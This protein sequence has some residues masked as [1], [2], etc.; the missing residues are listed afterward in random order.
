MVASQAI[1]RDKIMSQIENALEDAADDLE[2]ETGFKPP[3]D[4]IPTNYIYGGLTMGEIKPGKS[5]TDASGSPEVAETSG[6]PTPDP[7]T[8]VADP[9]STSLGDTVWNALLKPSP[10]PWTNT[11]KT[12]VDPVSGQSNP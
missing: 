9:E 12:L 10:K 2:I 4:K 5:T 11:G 3:W 1:P 8:V 7:K 6:K